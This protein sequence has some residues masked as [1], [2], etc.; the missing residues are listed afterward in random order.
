[1]E[2]EVITVRY[3]PPRRHR[4]ALIFVREDPEELHG[5]TPQLQEENCRRSCE[6][7]KIPVVRVVRV[8]CH[9]DESL[10]KLKDLLFELP[11]GVD[12]ILAARFYCYSNQLRELALMCLQFQC[13]G[14]WV[15]SLEFCF[16]IHRHL[17][18]LRP[19]DYDEADRICEELNRQHEAE[20]AALRAQ[21]AESG[22]SEV[23][24]AGE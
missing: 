20:L 10:L 14:A 3:L 13:R 5:L 19:A 2:S 9:S 16:P 8:S 1:M 11:E 17:M 22:P 15:Y 21:K 7:K 4:G 6:M 12:A 23:A 18:V 24:A